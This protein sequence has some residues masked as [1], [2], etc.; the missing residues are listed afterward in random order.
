MRWRAGQ[1]RGGPGGGHGRAHG[2]AGGQADRGPGWPRGRRGRAGR[3]G[4][5]AARAPGGRRSAGRRAPAARAGAG[6]GRAEGG[7]QRRADDQAGHR[8]RAPAPPLRNIRPV[9]DLA[10]APLWARCQAY[11]FLPVWLRF[12]VWVP[13]CMCMCETR[14]VC[15][16]ETP[17]CAK[18]GRNEGQASG[19]WDA[20]R[21]ARHA[22]RVGS[23]LPA[24]H[25]PSCLVFCGRRGAARGQGHRRER[26]AGGG[27]DR[28]GRHPAR[29]AGGC[30]GA[31][32]LCAERRCSCTSRYTS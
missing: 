15:M 2:Q 13:R 16:C 8:W 11:H 26:R 7:R 19:A 22:A 14:C 10:S 9:G 25:G 4:G 5:R 12:V 1:G 32:G 29:E 30:P 23:A 31:S 28:R 6:A 27:P 18:C 17:L 20:T 3:G 24:A 21:A